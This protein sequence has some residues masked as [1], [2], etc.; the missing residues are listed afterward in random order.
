[1]KVEHIFCLPVPEKSQ[2]QHNY[3]LFTTNST[4]APAKPVPGAAPIP[5][6]FVF[7]IADVAPKAGTI[8]GTE[9]AAASIVSDDYKTLFDWAIMAR[10]KAAGKGNV[11]I[12]ETDERLF[13]SVQKQPHRPK[14]KA[15]H[16]KAFRGSKDGKSLI[17]FPYIHVLT[18][19]ARLPLLP[20]QRHPLG[21]QKT[22]PLPLTH[23]NRRSLLHQRPPTHLQPFHRDGH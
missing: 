13:H 3:I 15:V 4:I 9:A 7:T 18:R 12:V 14:E 1:M 23:A 10:L 16:I 5:E 17:T 20:T 2:K 11:K 21:L 8:S 22:P 19:D 6:P